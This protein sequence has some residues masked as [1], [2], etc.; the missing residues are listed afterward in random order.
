MK[1]ND[2]L[3][4]VCKQLH[5]VFVPSGFTLCDHQFIRVLGDVSQDV[6]VPLVDYAP[7]FD[8]SL[9]VG[10]RVD[11]AEAI[12]SSFWDV[13]PQETL[14]C[15]FNLEDFVPQVG[16]WIRITNRRSLAR[17]LADLIP[18]LERDVLPFLDAHQDLGSID[19]LMNGANQELFAL[20][21]EPFH[22]M[23]SIIVAHLA[24][25][26]DRDQLAEAYRKR[27]W[28]GRGGQGREAYDRLVQFLMRSS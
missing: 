20:A 6:G 14:T 13:N 26:P 22:S 5:A 25:N 2:V 1:A 12:F 11:T 27:S 16:D 17:A 23:S 3:D 7:T 21:A 9:V 18:L 10:F 28:Y 8:F 19:R 24:R 4:L 15:S